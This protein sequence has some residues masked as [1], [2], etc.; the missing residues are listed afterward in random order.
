[1]ANVKTHVE[2]SDILMKADIND[3][4]NDGISGIARMVKNELG[5][6]VVAGES[7][8]ASS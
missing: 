6:N 2:E 5:Q 3:L 1:M 4:D 7:L 8:L